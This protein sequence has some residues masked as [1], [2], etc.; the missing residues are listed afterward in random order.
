VIAGPAFV[1]LP[2]TTLVVEPGHRALVGAGGDVTL[3][4]GVPA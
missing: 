3:E 2:T 4:P 1:E